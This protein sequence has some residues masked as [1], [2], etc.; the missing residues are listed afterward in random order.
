MNDFEED[1]IREIDD[2][3]EEPPAE[4]MPNEEVLSKDEV[5]NRLLGVTS[6]LN[7][8]DDYKNEVSKKRRS[9]AWTISDIRHYLMDNIDGCNLI[10]YFKVIRRLV[11][12]YNLRRDLASSDAIIYEFQK[13]INR[14]NNEGNRKMVDSSVMKEAKNWDKP[15]RNRIMSEEELQQLFFSNDL[16]EQDK[17]MLDGLV[18]AYYNQYLRPKELV[19]IEEPKRK[20]GRPRKIQVSPEIKEGDDVGTQQSEEYSTN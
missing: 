6:L 1:L 14:L 11:D 7:H 9:N 20:R 18:L 12:E 15:Y 19:T 3:V 10:G 4:Y 5:S 2:P 8:I 13:N 16:T 17:L